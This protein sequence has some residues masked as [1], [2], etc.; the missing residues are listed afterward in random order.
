MRNRR[1]ETRNATKGSLARCAKRWGGGVIAGVAASCLGIGSAAA[2]DESSGYNRYEIT[3]FVGYM[4]GGEFEDP[5]DGSERDLDADTNF[6]VIMNIAADPWRHY[7]L[8]YSNQ[9]TQLDGVTTLDMDV[10]YLQIGG[11]VS[12]PDAT[13]AIPY[14]GI[15]V[16]AAQFSPDETGLDDETELAFTVG[17]GMRIPVTDNIG[18]RFDA[19]AFITLLDGDSEIFC[20]SSEG[21]TCAIRTKSDT[22]L[23]YAASLG[24]TIGF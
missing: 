6:G 18:I 23:Q 22:F 15:T 20:V 4:A 11:T 21:A 5:T 2:A 13:H 24:V 10:Q 12:H 7:E 1:P 9:S 3:P 8:L 17:G 19:R 16:G 14:F